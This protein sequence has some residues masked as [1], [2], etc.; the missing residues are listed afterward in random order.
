MEKES[1][2]LKK[3]KK[4]KKKWRYSGMVEDMLLTLY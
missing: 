1:L 3:K 2:F 4:K